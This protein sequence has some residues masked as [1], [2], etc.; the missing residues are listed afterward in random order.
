[1]EIT[2]GVIRPEVDQFKGACRDWYAI[3]HFLI[4]SDDSAA[5]AWTAVDS[6][7]ITLQDINRGQWYEHLEIENGNVFAYVFNN[8][9]WTNYKA[10]Q[11]GQLTFRFAMTS[12]RNISD[13]QAKQF[14][15]SVQN[16]MIVKVMTGTSPENGISK[17]DT[18]HGLGKKLVNS[19]SFVTVDGE[20]VV[21]Q[22][23]M[24]ARFTGGTIIRLREMLGKASTVK[25]RITGIRFNRAYLCNLAE[26]KISP[27]SVN[28]KT[29]TVPCK[30]LGLT[31]VLLERS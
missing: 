22:A 21:V 28:N 27:L 15:E 2:N 5:V 20:G 31:T 6:P 11:G 18:E 7:L 17:N 4:V 1:L 25:L 3:Q 10:N 12:G 13:L 19:Q 8:Y 26:D 14:G 9:W 24:P 29:I 23:M 30:A 16:P